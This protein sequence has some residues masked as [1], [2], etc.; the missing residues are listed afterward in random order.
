MRAQKNL[1]LKQYLRGIG[2]FLLTSQDVYANPENIIR[3]KKFQIQ[4]ETRKQK[5]IHYVYL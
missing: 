5:K 3:L 2:Q 1:N 4:I